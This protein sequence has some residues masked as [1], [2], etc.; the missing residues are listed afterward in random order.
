MKF[1][2]LTKYLFVYA[3]V[4]L[5]G[6]LGVTFISYR[7]DY[8]KVYNYYTDALY[9]QAL[10]I[11]SE[12]ADDYFSEEHL[13]I[14]ETELRTVALLND[15]RIMFIDTAGNIILDTAYAQEH[16]TKD[17]L[18]TIDGFDYTSLGTK[19][20]QT[21]DF[22]GMLDC[23]CLSVFAPITSSFTM[24]GYVVVHLDE[25]VIKIKHD[26]LYTVAKLAFEGRLE[27]E[28]D[29]IAT[30]LIPGPTPQFRCCIY[31][32]REIIRQRVRLAEG[33][34]PGAEDDGNVIQVISS[35]CEDCPISS[36]TVTENCQN[37]LGKA[38]VNAC[39]FGAIEPG[40]DRSHIDPS[41]C[42]ECGRCAQ[43][44]PYNAI[45]HLKRPC[46]FSCPVNAITYNEYG[47][48]VIDKEKC[49]RCGKCIHSCPFGAIA[50]KTF[51]VP[52]IEALKAGKHIYA[53]AAPAT[54]G[55]FG[56]DITMASWKKAM[57]EMGFTDFYDVG[58]GGDMTAAYEAEEWAEAYKE[59]N[60]KVT[61]CCPA[62]V[63]M[64][65][66]HY[67]EL[68][69]CVSTTVSP[70]CAVSRLIKA[71]D[72]EAIT[73]FIGPCVAKKSE[74]ADQKI[75]GNADYVLTY[76]EI[77]AMMKAK[78]VEL[79][80]CANDDQTASTFGKRFANSGG[81]TAAVLESLKESNDEIAATVCKAN[82]AAECKKALLLLKAARLP[83]DFIEGMACEGGCVG[84]PS[85]FN[86]QVSS[87]KN[88]DTLIG[89]ADDR[90]IHDNL[91][92]Y[93]MESFSMHRE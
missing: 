47:I 16:N 49:I 65:R 2:L 36:Y 84:G 1:N 53:M 91:K 30:E 33:K 93:D 73:V 15:T 88:R 5:L 74:V 85:A 11:S 7:I 6:F 37:C 45:A 63:N 13:R 12:Y 68:A 54:E 89:Q 27:E 62:F 59:G 4:A 64:V 76:S 81:V 31:K 86:D 46:K 72:P 18:Y 55:Q 82:G 24:K 50:S 58:L 87:K 69:E 75:E 34:A 92:N 10:S 57:K 29:H 20:T 14:V 80:P 28:R 61:S 48:S 17:I 3:A 90:T 51:I 22:Y 23:T 60:K 71:K 35:A 70:M 42:K 9:K 41:K 43:A 8:A 67:P 79:Q 78:G 56:V 83:E 39:K 77:R 26:V 44:C 40:R 25:N 38:C 19:H 21:G 52:V 66:L 32:E